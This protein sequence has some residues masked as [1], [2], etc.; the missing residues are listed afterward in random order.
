M[1]NDAKANFNAA[2]QHAVQLQYIITHETKHAKR[3]IVFERDGM[4]CVYCGDSGDSVV[5]ECDHVIPVSKGVSHDLSNLATACFSCNK[6]KY[7]KTVEEWS[8]R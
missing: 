2:T 4:T 3:E 1:N 6:S 7:A 8:G 5:L